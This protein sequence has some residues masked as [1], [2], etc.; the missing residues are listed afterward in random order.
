MA[1]LLRLG[2]DQAPIV[3]VPMPTKR[4]ADV[5]L[6]DYEAEMLIKATRGR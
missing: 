2:T 4:G 5:P 6:A 1:K 3:A